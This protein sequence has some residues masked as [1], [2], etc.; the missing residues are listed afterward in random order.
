MSLTKIAF[1]PGL[2]K[3]DSPLA[4][5]GGWIDADKVRFVGGRPQTLGG[6]Q[7]AGGAFEGIARGA[8]AWAT[9]EGRRVMAWGTAAKLYAMVGG[10]TRDITPPHSEGVL[11]DPFTTAVGSAVVVVAHPEHGLRTG[12]T[13]VFTNQS[14]PVG[15]L[16]L[17]G[18][19]TVTVTGPDSYQVTAGGSA[20]GSAT[21]GGAVDY[22]A[23]LAPGLVHGGGEPGGYGSGGYG[24]GGYGGGGDVV[25]TLPRVW[26]LDNWGETLVA[27]P[28]RGALYQYQPA[29]TYPELVSGGEFNSSAGWTLGAGWSIGAGVASASA[30]AASDLSAPVEF[31]PGYVYRVS[32]A[33][34]RSA[35]ELVIRT[36]G[37]ALGAASTPIVVS[38]TYS[39][40]FRAPAG[41]TQIVFE[42]DAA[43]V[44]SIDN[45]SIKLE[46]IA[47][48][49]D[50]APGRSDAM[51]V[52]PHQIVVLLGTSPYG[53]VYNPM[54]LRWS[55]RQNLQ[56]WT[57]TVANLAGD[58]ILS[59]GSRL[60]AGTASRQ[61]NV[62]W[63]DSALYTMQYT[64]DAA[65]PF[66]FAL[67]GT[68][69]GLTGALAHAEHDGTVFWVGRGRFYLFNGGIPTPIPCKLERDFFDNL[70]VNQGEKI[71]CGILPGYSELWV[72]Y[73]DNRDGNEC[74]RY[75]AYRWD[76]NHWMSGTFARSAWI[77]PGIF[78][79][80]IMFGTDGVVYE[81][82]FG[83]SANGGAID[84]FLES[85]YYDIGDGETL[86]LIRRII[87]DFEELDGH[88][89][90]YLVGRMWPTGD[91][92]TYGPFR[93]LP[94]TRKLDML[95]SARQFKLIVRS[96]A[97]PLY[98]RWGAVS[99]DVV[100][101]G[102]RH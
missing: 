86:A 32:V 69:C 18:S 11:I 8:H 24:E 88:V 60:I 80:P 63:S 102:A 17:N 65:T 35:G 58:D 96:S 22:T 74:S 48:R 28:R 62:L 82:E 72:L 81:H 37:G 73:P 34:T 15:G 20:S 30:G 1:A 44:G 45:V 36:D 70:A 38:G 49:I 75:A 14:V 84:A 95:A 90:F 93:H 2:N 79:Y 101:T 5:E 13:I 67:S 21:G 66:V 91:E 54:A 27:L 53:G 92:K 57:P 97:A 33:V 10:S 12:Q 39:R 64:G 56:D 85:A 42:K 89:D 47:Y 16:V 40:R 4:S 83:K 9:Q 6:W 98:W 26:F 43:F 23:A 51:F 50:E 71:A 76:E 78:E 87:G 7:A 3:D 25:D 41:S 100:Q 61:Q 77:K 46:A 59:T 52:D 94:T 19:R 31:I 55:G 68:G 99:V 29:L